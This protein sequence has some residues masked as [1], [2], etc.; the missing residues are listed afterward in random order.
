MNV[1]KVA[2]AKFKLILVDASSLLNERTRPMLRLQTYTGC[3]V[4]I[5]LIHVYQSV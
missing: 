5:K 3:G 4:N 2:A 1:L